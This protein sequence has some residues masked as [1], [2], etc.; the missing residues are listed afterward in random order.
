[1]NCDRI[2]GKFHDT[3]GTRFD[4]EHRQDIIDVVENL[5]SHDVDDLVG[6]LA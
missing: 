5:E 4:D 6:L 3:A 2:Q 1:M